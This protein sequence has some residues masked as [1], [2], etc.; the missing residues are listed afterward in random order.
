MLLRKDRESVGVALGQRYVAA[1]MVRSNNSRSIVESVLEKSS[2]DLFNRKDYSR[3]E[4]CLSTVLKS[5]SAWIGRRYIPVYMAIPDPVL[6]THSMHFDSFPKGRLRQQQLVTW[7]VEKAFHMPHDTLS[8]AFFKDSKNIPGTHVFAGAIQKGLLLT[9]N[10]A[11]AS[12]NI[13]PEAVTM[14]SLCR[15]AGQAK[16][17][18]DIT[19]HIRLDP[20]YICI[21]VTDNDG[22]PYFIRSFWRRNDGNE[23]K[24]ELLGLINDVDLT[25]HAYLVANPGKQFDS[26]TLNVDQDFERDIFVN[27]FRMQESANAVDLSSR[28]ASLYSSLEQHDYYFCSAI[29]AA[30]I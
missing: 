13:E 2:D 3:L 23:T 26:V 24:E 17:S 27:H 11:F 15:Q 20:E 30:V 9:I 14:A 21:A 29:D 1:V 22:M 16:A 7:Q 6:L 5:V 12:A 28:E 8:V 18:M 25:L 10:R 19:A 4:H